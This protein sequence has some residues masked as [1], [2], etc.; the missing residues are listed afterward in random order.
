MLKDLPRPAPSVRVRT[1]P[2]I[3]STPARAV[4][5]V[6]LV[7]AV[8]VSDGQFTPVLRCAEFSRAIILEFTEKMR[9]L[10]LENLCRQVEVGGRLY[11][12]E[13]DLYRLEVHRLQTVRRTR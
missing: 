6:G 8:A 5:V 3:D 7:E 2:G 10:A 12:V 4:E 11:P 13:A 9:K 1:R